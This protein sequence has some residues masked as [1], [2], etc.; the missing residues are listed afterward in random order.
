M[1]LLFESSIECQGYRDGDDFLVSFIF[2]DTFANVF[3]DREICQLPARR[4][5][6]TTYSRL[7]RQLCSFSS[8]AFSWYENWDLTLRRRF[9]LVRIDGIGCGE[10]NRWLGFDSSFEGL[11]FHFQNLDLID[12]CSVTIVNQNSSISHLPPWRIYLGKPQSTRS[13]TKSAPSSDRSF[14]VG[15]R[16]SSTILVEKSQT[17]EEQRVGRCAN[18]GS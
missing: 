6:S 8:C 3:I 18:N 15:L 10:Q 11:S 13:R 5:C 17:H 1:L 16:S 14:S 4:S 12:F 7:E 9:P 2:K